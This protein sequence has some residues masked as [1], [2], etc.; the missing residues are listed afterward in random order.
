MAAATTIIAGASLA[1]S[2]AATAKGV[3][4]AKKA[5][6]DAGNYKRQKLKNSAEDIQ[7]STKGADII[8]EEGSRATASMIGAVKRGGARAI[9]AN[10]GKI[11]S[12]NLKYQNEAALNIDRQEQ[13][14]NKMIADQNFEVQSMYERR[15]EADLRGLGAQ[16]EA[17]KQTTW[18][19]L[20][21]MQ[22]SVA[23]GANSGAFSKAPPT[24][25]GK[26]TTLSDNL[27]QGVKS[28]F[29][30]NNPKIQLSNA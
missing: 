8:R 28:D 3:V 26:V 1:L 10:V 4:D 30:Y 27:Q 15:E 29:K 13:Y 23:Y 20:S 9:G 19:G 21:A 22:N 24:P 12:Q 14:R 5:K 11:T 18:N 7:I 25:R 2:A 16:M 6:D 17:A